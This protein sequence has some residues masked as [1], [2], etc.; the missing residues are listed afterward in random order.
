M[1][2]KFKTTQPT[3]TVPMLKE[4]LAIQEHLDAGEPLDQAVRNMLLA[5]MEP[6]DWCGG[7]L[8]REPEGDQHID[9]SCIRYY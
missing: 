9:F 5:G 6:P 4:K 3:V 7:F 1:A 2:L 8:C